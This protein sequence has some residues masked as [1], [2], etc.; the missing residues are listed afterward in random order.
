MRCL[1]GDK[2]KG[3]DFILQQEEFAYNNFV[4]N[5]TRKSPFRIVYGRSPRN[6]YEL[7]T[8]DKGKISSAK[9]EDFVEHLKNIHE[10]VRKHITKMNTQYKNKENIK[11]EVYEI[12]YWRW[13]HGSFM[14]RAF[15]SRD[16]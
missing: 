16:I 13:S 12:L 3:W 7:R 5:S 14:K 4:N 11:N 2:P 9:A 6:D 10:E 8:L 15:S 1:V